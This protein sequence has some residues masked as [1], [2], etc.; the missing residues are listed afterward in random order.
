M[1]PGNIEIL[2]VIAEYRTWGSC[3]RSANNTSVPCNTLLRLSCL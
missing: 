3:V 2:T 1:L